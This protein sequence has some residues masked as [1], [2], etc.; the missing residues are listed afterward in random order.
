MHRLLHSGFEAVQGLEEN[1]AG[2]ALFLCLSSR[3]NKIVELK[4]E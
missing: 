4:N 1:M 3:Y 2:F